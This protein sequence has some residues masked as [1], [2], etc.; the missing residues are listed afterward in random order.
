M[1]APATCPCTTQTKEVLEAMIE[2]CRF[3]PKSLKAAPHACW[4]RSPPR[5][6]DGGMANNNLMLQLQADMLGID[7]GV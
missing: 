2:D 1:H 6:V 7:V 3:D 4:R 5:Q